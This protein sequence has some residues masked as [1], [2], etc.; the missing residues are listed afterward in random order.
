[1]LAFLLSLADE[2]DHDKIVYIYEHFHNDMMR[3]ARRRL[4]MA[5]ATNRAS[6]AED[7]VQNSFYKLTKYVKA[8]DFDVTE[9]ELRAYVLA[10]VVNE[11]RDELED[12]RNFDDID[13]HR[14]LSINEDFLENFMIRERYKKVVEAI[15][16]LKDKYRMA[17]EYHYYRGYSVKEMSEMLELPEKTI[18]TRLLRAKKMIKAMLDGEDSGDESEPEK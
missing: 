12:E 8:I 18:Y 1:M 2:S 6:R 16:Q 7:I 14:D 13:D 5:N 10:T 15:E 9:R 4:Y 11:T 17:L 3:V